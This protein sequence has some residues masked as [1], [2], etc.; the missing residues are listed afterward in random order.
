M[1]AVVVNEID[2]YGVTDVELDPP[3]AGEVLIKMKAMSAMRSSAMTTSSRMM[4]SPY[5][6]SARLTS[7]NLRSKCWISALSAWKYC[8]VPLLRA[9]MVTP[10]LRPRPPTNLW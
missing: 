7:A 4:P 1:K 2:N 5:L 3:K 10:G 9:R 8:Q 6:V